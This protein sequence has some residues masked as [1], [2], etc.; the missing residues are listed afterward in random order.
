MDYSELAIQFGYSSLFAVAF[1]LARA[2]CL[3][4]NIIEQRLDAYKICRVYRR[5]ECLTRESIGAWGTV[6][7]SLAVGSVITNALLVGFVGSQLADTIGVTAHSRGERL[8]NHRLWLSAVALEHAILLFRFIIKTMVPHEPSWVGK[9]KV[10]L[11]ASIKERMQT[12]EEKEEEIDALEVQRESSVTSAIVGTRIASHIHKMMVAHSGRGLSQGMRSHLVQLFYALDDNM[13]GTL[14]NVE[15]QA[16]CQQDLL[17]V[18]VLNYDADGSGVLTMAEWLDGWVR[19]PWSEDEM[20]LHIEESM[21]RLAADPDRSYLPAE[22][23]R[24]GGSGEVDNNVLPAL[25]RVKGVHKHAIGMTFAFKKASAEEYDLGDGSD[26]SGA[27]SN[28][29]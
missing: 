14:T 3:I 18:D 6:F 23:D 21:A 27:S 8:I 2:M 12:L 17:P 26:G 22:D 4:S 15:L 25:S 13:S 11:E 10:Q 5:P 19:N 20:L 29:V 1:P 9:A 28:C 16:Y 24:G 7:D